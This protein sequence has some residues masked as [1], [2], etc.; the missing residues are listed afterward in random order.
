MIRLDDDALTADAKY[1]INFIQ[2]GK[3]ISTL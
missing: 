2:S 1:P 3:Q